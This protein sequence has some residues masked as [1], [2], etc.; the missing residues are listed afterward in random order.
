M[1]YD[2]WLLGAGNMAKEYVKVL[3][4]LQVKTLVIGRS[5]KS[6]DDLL[7]EFTL[8][9]VYGGLVSHKNLLEYPLP[10]FAIIAVSN[11]QL[12][13]VALQLI[14]LGIK[15]ILVEKPAGLHF[16]SVLLLQEEAKRTGIRLYVAYNRRFYT[17]V[18]YLKE[19]IAVEGGIASVSFEFTEWV[20]TFDTNLYPPEV[21]SRLLIVN[22]SHVLD[23]VFHLAGKPR[24]LHAHV[25]GNA[26]VWH[27]AGSVFTGSGLTEKNIPF[28]Y[29]SNWGAPGRWAIEITTRQKRYYLKPLE[30]LAVQ[31]KG[32]VQVNEMELDYS[33]DIAFKPGLLELTKA[34]FRNDASILC[35][36]DEHVVNFE[37]YEKIGNYR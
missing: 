1:N 36:I 10:E 16:D 32:S 3:Q 5:K 26:V 6:V 4:E 9:A 35:T 22:S 34:F 18:N 8:D 15:N 30:R 17:S 28:S 24:E 19:R 2:C 37:F 33:K 11:E 27:P 31:E 13:D 23:T 21:L 14:G 25:G 29:A 7:A 12:T 20:H